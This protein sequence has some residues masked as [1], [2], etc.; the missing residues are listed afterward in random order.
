MATPLPVNRAAFT[1]EEIAAAT[2]GQVIAPAGRML[3]GVSTDSRHAPPGSIFVALVGES[4]DGHAFVPQA[5]AAGAG[6]LIVSRDVGAPK[7]VAVIRVADTLRALG[8]LAAAHRRRF[9]VP[10]IAITGS[11]GKTTTK[12]LTT[13]ALEALGLRVHATAGNLNNLIGLPLTLL[14]LE[15]EHQVVVLEMGMNTPGEIARLA[16]IAQPTIGVVTSVAEVHTEGVGSIDAI[17]RE[18]GALFA[19]LPASGG[20]VSTADDVILAPYLEKSPAATRV[21]FGIADDADV[22]LARYTITREGTHCELA[23]RGVEERVNVTLA[24]LGEG[25][26]RS[27]TAAIAAIYAFRGAVAVP[28][29]AAGLARVRP[30]E[31]RARPLPGPNGSMLIDD[32]YNASPRSTELALRAVAEIAAG[33]GGRAIAVLGDMKELGGE[34]ERLHEELGGVAVAAGIAILVCCGEAMRA[35]A[36]GALTASLASGVSGIRIESVASPTEATELVRE[37]ILPTDVVL[38]KGSRSMHMERVV[39]ALRAGAVGSE[40]AP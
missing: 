24:L 13:A 40:V 19:H 36:R 23:I 12:D 30:G 3:A 33:G 5:C 18:K 7:N 31:G 28:A 17:A 39:D 2:G 25:P 10:V 1:V 26:A 16:A 20:A 14:A 22:C 4:H 37:L 34:T 32:A 35:T 27:A 9:E 21:R 11:V 38:V 29:A 6:A 15:A 8:D